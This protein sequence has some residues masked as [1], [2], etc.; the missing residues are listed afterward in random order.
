MY[1]VEELV[2]GEDRR[3]KNEYRENEKKKRIVRTWNKKPDCGDREAEN[4]YGKVDSPNN[5]P[6]LA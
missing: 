4:S 3:A 2:V 1:S 5:S 6:S